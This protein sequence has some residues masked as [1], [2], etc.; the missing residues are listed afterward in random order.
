[1]K[2][3]KGNWLK[4]KGDSLNM[5]GIERELIENGRSIEWKCEGMNWKWKE[6]KGNELKSKGS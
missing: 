4:V 3:K 5:K 1:M 2:G 6:M